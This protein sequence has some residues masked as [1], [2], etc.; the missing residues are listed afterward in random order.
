M[1]YSPPHPCSSPG[2]SALVESGVSMCPLHRKQQQQQRGTAH[3][4]GYDRD[5]ALCRTL[6][7]KAHEMCELGLMCKDGSYIQ[8]LAT[9]VHHK[10]PIST[11]PHLRLDHGNLM[12]LC[13]ACHSHVT[14]QEHGFGRN[15]VR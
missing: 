3:A 13:A 7:L 4:R 1:P 12:A 11:H 5:W 15:N 14:A 6:Y 2:C 10:Q 9:Q 8:R